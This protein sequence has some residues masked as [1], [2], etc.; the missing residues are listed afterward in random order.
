MK[1][2]FSLIVLALISLLSFAGCAVKGGSSAAGIEFIQD[3]FYVDYE[4]KTFLDYKVYPKTAQ[5]VYV[6]YEV[7]NDL[8]AESYFKFSKGEI[9]VI[10]KKFTSVKII[11]KLNEFTDMCEVRLKEYPDSVK[12]DKTVDYINANAI[13]PLN[14]EGVFKGETLSCK[15]RQYVFKVESSNPS[16]IEIISEKDLLVKSTGRSGEAKIDVKIC[17]SL[18]QEKVG[19]KASI[20]LKVIENINSAFIALDY[21]HLTNNKVLDLSLQP[22]QEKKLTVYYF[23]E[24]NV[25]NEITDFEIFLTNDYVFDIIKKDNIYY[26]KLKDLPKTE[27]D[28]CYLVNL[29]IQSSALKNNGEPYK[30]MCQIQVHIL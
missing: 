6:N 1:K 8:M 21:T 26:L 22:N 11:A 15:D 29:V 19:L 14:L 23:G 4:V 3:V 17:D 10:N 9:E 27:E 28:E 2:T 20:T 7:E 5:N 16:V 25:L 18:N 13:Y 24:D 30:L 12:F